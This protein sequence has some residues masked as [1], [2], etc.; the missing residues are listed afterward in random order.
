MKKRRKP[1][2]PVDVARLGGAEDLSSY[3]DSSR[4]LVELV[5]ELTWPAVTSGQVDDAVKAAELADFWWR[6]ISKSVGEAEARA[7]AK[8][9][10]PPGNS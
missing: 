3:L 7:R 2:D 1:T 9:T 6:R 5:L 10:P 4:A 8:L